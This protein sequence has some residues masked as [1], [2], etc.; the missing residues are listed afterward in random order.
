[1]PTDKPRFTVTLDQELLNRIDN[2]KFSHR[3]KNQNQAV[4][5]LIAK[6]F[7][8]LAAD[9]PQIKN[10]PAPEGAEERMSLEDSTAMLVE[11]GYIRPGEQ[12]SDADLAFFE[13]IVGLM[14]AWFDSKKP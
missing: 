1:M 3:M 11:L 13:H 6:G 9:Q 10:S 8:S 14:D 7:D 4:V 2:Y 12:L 5:S